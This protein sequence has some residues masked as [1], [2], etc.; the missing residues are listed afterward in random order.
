MKK[1]NQW[2]RLNTVRKKVLL[3]SKLAGGMICLF[4]VFTSEL[5]TSR[6]ITFVI[7]LALL[8]AVIIGVDIMLGRFISEP[9]SEINHAAGQ[10]AELDFSAHCSISTEDEFGELSQN[11]NAM[12][13]NLR[14]ALDNLEA[15]NM[16][17]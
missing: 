1:M 9:L 8:A 12:F 7:W 4:Y 6:S 14:E 5:Q 10:M 15:A 17:E 2:F 16:T 13:S 3:L 11:L